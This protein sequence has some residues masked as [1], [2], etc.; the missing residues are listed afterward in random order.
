MHHQKFRLLRWLSIPPMMFVAWI[1]SLLLGFGLRDVAT[2]LCPPAEIVSGMCG[3]AWYAH[4]EQGIIAGCAGFA[5]ALIL[6][7]TVLLAPSHRVQLASAVLAGGVA[8]AIYMAH[9]TGAWDCFGAATACGAITWLVL[10]R[11]ATTDD[12]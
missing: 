2:R 5:A 10:K 9:M 4:A 3:A 8:V 6:V 11:R 1:L 7:T 12:S